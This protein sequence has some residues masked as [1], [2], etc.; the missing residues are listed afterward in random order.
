M[1]FWWES[2][3]HLSRKEKA[4][5]SAVEKRLRR[6]R[7]AIEYSWLVGKRRFVMLDRLTEKELRIL[8]PCGFVSEAKR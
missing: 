2:S 3:K 4:V 1:K 8:M 7:S 6:K 5:Y